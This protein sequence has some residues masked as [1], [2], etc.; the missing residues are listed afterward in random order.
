MR[1]A[2]PRF[3]RRAARQRICRQPPARRL[4]T[5]L[6]HPTSVEEAMTISWASAGADFIAAIERWIGAPLARRVP[7]A[8]AASRTARVLREGLAA[9]AG[10]VEFVR[11]LPPELPKA[12]ASSSSVD[13]WIA[14]P[15]R[16]S[17]PA[18]RVRRRISTAAREH[19]AR[20]KPAPDLYLH[21]ADQLGVPIADCVDHRGFAGRRRR[22][23]SPRA[24]GSSAWSPGAI[25]CPAMASGCARSASRDIAHDFDEVARGCSA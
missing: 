12:V 24:R 14:A 16:P 17:R 4:L 15:P 23:R 2:D 6:G 25:A 9:V 13:R 19:V 3:R 21:A 20:G 7:R 18:R 1:R 8:R 11:A 10:A 5:E 22:A